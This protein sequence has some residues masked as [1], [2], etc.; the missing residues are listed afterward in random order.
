[1]SFSVSV[2]RTFSVSL[3][4]SLLRKKLQIYVPHPKSPRLLSCPTD[5]GPDRRTS[6]V[7][8][9]YLPL[10]SLFSLYLCV[11]VFLSL[12]QYPCVHLF[13]VCLSLSFRRLWQIF[14]EKKSLYTVCP[15][16][17]DP[18]YI[19]NYYIKWV[20]TPWTHRRIKMLFSSKSY[21]II[22]KDNLNRTFFSD[23]ATIMDL[24]PY[25]YLDGWISNWPDILHQAP[26]LGRTP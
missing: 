25:Y 16:S 8:K 22:T 19:V 20:T 2:S 5:T 10:F 7:V 17:S 11:Y 12:F 1:M 18:F 9:Y 6:S 4:L 23:P 14:A 26:M 24:Y 15:R 21:N 3:S 13:S